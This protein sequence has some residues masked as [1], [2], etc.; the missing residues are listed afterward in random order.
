MIDSQRF[1][2]VVSAILARAE[3]ELARRAARSP[4]P[5]L[6]GWMRPALSAAAAVAGI[7][8]AAT[9]ALRAETRAAPPPG[10][11]EALGVPTA[12][13]AW[14]ETGRVPAVDELV[15]TLEG[16]HR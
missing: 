3:P 7:A 6:A 16:D 12:V 1:E 11:A 5:V 8:V 14:L 10:V 9:L 2:A 15:V 13:S 4:F